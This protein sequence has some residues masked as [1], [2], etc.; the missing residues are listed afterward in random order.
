MNQQ[1]SFM[2]RA[3]RWLTFGA[4][5]SIMF[6]IAAFNIFMGLALAAL[7]FSGEKLRVPRIKLPLGVFMALTVVAWIRSPDPWIDG[8][9]QIRK[10]W[11]FC[12]LLLVFST[13]RSLATVRWLFL[14]WVGLASI[15]ALRGFV[16]FAGKMQAA[17][18]SG[19]DAYTYYVAERITGF[20]SH[21]NT[22][23][24]Q[25]MF[26]LVMLGALLLFGIHVPDRK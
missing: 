11:V 25:E 4:A 15:S 12:I 3:A 5:A 20:S 23:S 16:Q 18:Q 7:F 24:A 6:S 17:H 2:S 14:T 13:L 22:F 9:P 19:V 1:E 10:F 8:Y 21:W 26:A